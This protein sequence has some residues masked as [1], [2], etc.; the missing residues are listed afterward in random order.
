MRCSS[1]GHVGRTL[2]LR[3]VCFALAGETAG[4]LF[5]L[6]TAR[7]WLW[8][9]SGVHTKSR[10]GHLYASF[11]CGLLPKLFESLEPPFLLSLVLLASHSMQDS[12]IAHKVLPEREAGLAP[13]S[14]SRVAF[15]IPGVKRAARTCASFRQEEWDARGT[16]VSNV[17]DGRV[18][19]LV[20][21][22]FLHHP[23][24]FLARSQRIDTGFFPRLYVNND[25]KAANLLLLRERN[26]TPWQ[27]KSLTPCERSERT[28]CWKHD[29]QST[30]PG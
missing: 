18:E 30:D 29:P 1:N 3:P 27:E 6:D 26:V 19:D 5:D 2:L 28:G 24:L 11:W 25:R 9:D 22:H 13:L 15:L 21:P 7:Q 10:T 12:P 14:P 8:R 17:A 20:V 4:A 16:Q 23:Y